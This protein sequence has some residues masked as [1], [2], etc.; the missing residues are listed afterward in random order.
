MI[1]MSFGIFLP[2]GDYNPSIAFGASI[3]N[4][5]ARQANIDDQ[6][7]RVLY[8]IP[9]ILNFYMLFIF[10]V[11]IKED[12]IMFNLSQDNDSKALVLIDKIY[13]KSEDRNVI[14]E[15][16]KS[17]VQKKEKISISFFEGVFGPKHRKTTFVLLTITFLCQQAAINV[18]N[19]ASTRL[20]T[21]INEGISSSEKI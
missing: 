21:I 7:W 8:A 15:A 6:M 16:L 3:E 1:C 18:F 13:H 10:I 20:M 14:L 5:F 12:S 17:Q 19:I 11:F 9:L 4:D 2:Q